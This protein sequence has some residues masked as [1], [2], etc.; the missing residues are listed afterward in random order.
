[1]QEF[2]NSPLQAFSPHTLVFTILGFFESSCIYN[3]YIYIY[4][5][6]FYDYVL[7]VIFKTVAVKA[8]QGFR[9]CEQ[10]M[11]DW[12]CQQMSGRFCYS[13]ELIT[14]IFRNMFI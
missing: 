6:E 12:A 9:A 10:M 13:I 8:D 3:I 2:V 5:F 14:A 1:M 7:Y 4:I 11:H